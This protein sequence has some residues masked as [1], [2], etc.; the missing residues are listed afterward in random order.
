MRVHAGIGCGFQ[1]IVYQNAL[2]IELRK[3][4]LAYHCEHEMP[5]YY[6]GELVG[7]RRVDVL[8]EQRVA[9]ELKAVTTLEN[10]HLA[11]AKNYL[12]AYKLRVGLLINFGSTSLQF[13]R[14]IN[15]KVPLDVALPLNPLNRPRNP[16]KS[17]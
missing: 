10:I 17:A 15:S 2:G 7:S 3:E 8:V 13:K 14:L 11:Q 6:L 4:G 9:V 16:P 1:E 5:I 12:E